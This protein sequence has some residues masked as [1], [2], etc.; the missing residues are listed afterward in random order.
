MDDPASMCVPLLWN[1]QG[2][3]GDLGFAGQ[4]D[5]SPEWSFT[6]K[7]RYL[8]MLLGTPY[9]A[10]VFGVPRY[11]TTCGD[12]TCGPS[13]SLSWGMKLLRAEPAGAYEFSADAR[14]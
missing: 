5:W 11:L 7:M 3:V 2:V 9:L 6:R 13:P 1:G 8:I 14:P 4:E 10:G 12:D